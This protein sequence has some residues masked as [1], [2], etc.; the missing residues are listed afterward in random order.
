MNYADLSENGRL[1]AKKSQPK[2]HPDYKWSQS[3]FK[4]SLAHQHIN[5][6][7]H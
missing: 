5:Q 1:L 7:A 6:L 3:V 2:K 4:V